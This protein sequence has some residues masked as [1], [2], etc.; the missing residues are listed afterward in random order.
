[1]MRGPDLGYPKYST[2]DPLIFEVS[3]LLL[4]WLSQRARS[5]MGRFDKRGL[6]ERHEWVHRSIR[7]LRR[8]SSEGGKREGGGWGF[9]GTVAREIKLT[10]SLVTARVFESVRDNLRC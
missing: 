7:C 8:P 2:V 9:K 6:K 1:M 10:I 5:M 4:G 3:G